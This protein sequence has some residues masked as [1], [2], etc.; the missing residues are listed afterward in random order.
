MEFK[1]DEA[2]EDELLDEMMQS[3][4]EPDRHQPSVSGMIKCITRTYYENEI[5]TNDE[6][7]YSRREAQLFYVGLGLEKVILQG[8]QKAVKGEV[9]SIQ[10]HVDHFG[11]DNHLLEIKSTRI[12]MMHGDEVPN[13]PINYK[14]QILSYMKALGL[15]HTAKVHIVYLHITGDYAPP[16][17]DIR[18]YQ[19]QTTDEEIEDNWTWLSQRAVV[20][21]KAQRDGQPPEP[22]Q[23]NESWEC[24]DCPWK[25]ACDARA[26]VNEMRTM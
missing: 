12:K 7:S 8:R 26:K 16:F 20:Y 5:K 2:L 21:M 22:F 1:R 23:W 17:P 3:F 25:I 18:A 15:N 19:I 9:D 13:I 24:K 11:T 4:H 14:R 10:F 6:P